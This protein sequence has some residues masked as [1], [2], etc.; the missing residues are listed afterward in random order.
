M[1]WYASSLERS[2]LSA[3]H[4]L[5]LSS[6]FGQQFPFKVFA[7][8][9]TPKRKIG[10]NVV[11]SADIKEI[12]KIRI[13]R[14]QQVGFEMTRNQICSF[15]LQICNDKGIPHP[16]SNNY[17][18]KDWLY[19]FMRRNNDIVKRKAEIFSY[20]RLMRFN[21]ELVSADLELL[22]KTIDKMNLY[23]QPHLIY[24]VD[25]SGL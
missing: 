4:S 1:V 5:L 3:R 10:R 7:E 2:S 9:I 6:T 21:W 8:R 23:N 18:G 24:N 20:C 16:F 11:L 25:E 15:A 12:F 14:L 13:I 19:G 17:A 22:G